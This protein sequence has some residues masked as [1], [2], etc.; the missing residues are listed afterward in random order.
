MNGAPA[1][2]DI[3]SSAEIAAQDR[4]G[5]WP[6]TRTTRTTKAAAKPDSEFLLANL[7]PGGGTGT[8]RHSPVCSGERSDDGQIHAAAPS[9]G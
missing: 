9:R 3:T 8:K 1:G 5:W 2:R 6:V 4:T 7:M